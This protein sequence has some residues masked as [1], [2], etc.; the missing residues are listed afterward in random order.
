MGNSSFRFDVKINFNKE[1]NTGF[2]WI[3]GELDRFDFSKHSSEDTKVQRLKPLSELVLCLCILKINNVPSSMET[4]IVDWAWE[5]LEKGNF[6]YRLLIARPDLIQVSSAYI[7]LN[8]VYGYENS[9]LSNLIKSLKEYRYP[10][11]LETEPWV[12]LSMLHSFSVFG[13]RNLHEHEFEGT[14]LKGYPEPWILNDS[15]M[16]ALT[17]EIFYLTDFGR[18]KFID[19]KLFDYL[20]LWLPVWAEVY[21]KKDNADL[22]SELLMVR[23]FTIADGWDPSYPVSSVLSLQNEDGSFNGPKGAGVNLFTDD[24]D[25]QSKIFLERYHTTLVSCVAL[26]LM[27]ID[28]PRT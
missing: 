26:S 24:D 18:K 9:R 2:R 8:K 6:I 3:R 20:N 4:E 21:A 19:R 1:V 17:H 15:M 13:I 5:K 16:Y 7:Y 28:S 12:K 14:W 10:Y 27:G 23:H 11:L 22:V 25:E